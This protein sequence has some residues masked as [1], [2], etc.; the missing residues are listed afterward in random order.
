MLLASAKVPDTLSFVGKVPPA[1]LPSRGWR[2]FKIRGSE[3]G[4]ALVPKFLAG[5]GG[6]DVL[7][8]SH[9][10]RAMAPWL[11]LMDLVARCLCRLHYSTV[12]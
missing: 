9:G 5:V 6:L 7:L 12:P 4:D 1:I 3:I 11:F 2:L 8:K 10:A